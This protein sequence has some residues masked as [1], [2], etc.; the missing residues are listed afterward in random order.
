[1]VETVDGAA[2]KVVARADVEVLLD[3]LPECPQ[4]VR[5]LSPFDPL[6]RDRK[7]LM[8]LFGFDYRIEIFV[9]AALRRYGYYV[10]PLLEGERLIGRIDMKAHAARGA[11]EVAALWLEPG[12]RMSGGRRERLDAELERIR[13]FVGAETV[14]YADGYLR[15][16]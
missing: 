2:R 3:S 7:R 8:A 12:R 13:R 11:L 9:P 1:L 15:P 14:H 6:L 10:F 4:R 16:R 5:V